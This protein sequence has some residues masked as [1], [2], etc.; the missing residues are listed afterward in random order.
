[1]PVR[2]TRN[3][4]R[5]GSTGCSCSSPAPLE[6]LAVEIYEN[7]IDGAAYPLGLINH[8]VHPIRTSD[9]YVHDNDMTLRAPTTRVRAVAFNGL[10]ELF[11]PGANNRFDHNTYR[12]PD[13]NAAYWAW[14]DQLS[15]TWSQWR[16]YGEDLNGRIAPIN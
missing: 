11:S 12:V 6:P 13:I 8:N 16:A 14:N 3:L 15:L 2:A 4:S 9:V 5:L 7:T 1:V 10:T